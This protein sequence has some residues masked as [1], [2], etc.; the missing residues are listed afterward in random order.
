MGI[1]AMKGTGGRRSFNLDTHACFFSQVFNAF[2]SLELSSGI[3]FVDGLLL[4]VRD[5]EM[6]D[7]TK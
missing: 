2:T 1:L 3:L 5:P 7:K 6:P 4:F